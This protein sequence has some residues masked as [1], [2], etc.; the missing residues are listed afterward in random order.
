[1]RTRRLMRVARAIL[2][3]AVVLPS[4]ALVGGGPV[5]AANTSSEML[6]DPVDR[7]TVAI[8]GGVRPFAGRDRYETALRLAERYAHERGGLG[9]ISTVILASGE[10]LVD[11]AVTAGLAGREKAPVL[12][13]PPNGLRG[14]V[15]AFLDRHRISTVIVVGGSSSVPRRVLDQIAALDVEPTV[16][17]IAGADRF[18]T[19]AAVAVEIDSDATWCGTDDTVAVLANGSDER[20]A[21]VVAI[22]PLAY[23]RELPVLLTRGSELPDAAASFLR[24]QRID[25][26]VIVGGES[27]VSDAVM[28]PLL[29]AGVDEIE[30][31]AASRTASVETAMAE[32]MT[33]DCL[34]ELE[35]SK[36]FV[37]L[38]GR[39]SVVDAVAAGPTLGAGFDGSGP[40]PLLL[41]SKPLPRAVQSFLSRTPSA[42]DGR[43]NHVQIVAIGGRGAIDEATMTAA[44]GAAA[45]ARALTARITAAAGANTLRVRFS[46]NLEVDVERFKAKL[47]DLLYVNEVPAWITSQDLVSSNPCGRFS[48]LNVTLRD[49]LEIDDE[50]EF[51][52][53]EGWHSTNGDRR[54]IRGVSYTV[55]EP[56]LSRRA[57]SIEVIA[58][59][60]Q[61]KVWIAVRTAELR[62]PASGAAD[63]IVVSSGRIRV[64]TDDGVAVTVGRP[65]QEGVRPFLG[66]ALYS[67]ELNASAGG[68][69]PLEAGDLVLVRNGVAVGA[70]DQRSGSSRA[71]VVEVKTRLG[72]AAVRAGPPN[73]GVDDSAATTRPDEIANVSRR[74][75]TRLG[76]ALRI[77][78]KWTGS[79]AG[80]A[81][82]A[83][84]I[85]SNRA[86]SP[87]PTP[88][89]TT[90]SDDDRPDTQVWIDASRQL[91]SIRHIEALE[92]QKREQTY[93]ELVQALNRNRDFAEHFIAELIDPCDG[94][95][96]VVDLDEDEGLLGTAELE[97]GV[98]SISFLVTYNEYVKGYLGDD[99]T[100]VSAGG[101]AHVGELI[102]DIL[103]ALI[104]DYDETPTA[105]RVEVST[106]LPLKQVFFRF[107]T[108]DPEHTIGQVAAIRS[109]RVDIRE[110]TVGGYRIDDPATDDV[111]ESVNAE[112]A[113]F[114]V[115]SRDSLLLT[116][117]PAPSS[118]S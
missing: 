3:S 42:V 33:K 117:L 80:A 68:N 105:D 30:R 93:G 47:R 66:T 97:G 25:R 32:L 43:K 91:I 54:V 84:T 40:I 87:V 9:S 64:I 100:V 89:T 4:L 52:A 11:G 102:D 19:A 110:G 23:A 10:T 72:V 83:W 69:Y 82:N 14:D 17:R 59:P 104:P 60:G 88:G 108:A 76:D 101:P 77:V 44:V 98:S 5:H 56:R 28:S 103:G 31:V 21:D 51:Q 109:K 118:N 26:V 22:G 63:D 45:S 96:V 53:A 55:P 74:A 81:G 116:D 71:L 18:A 79:A 61:T 106:L 115:S 20:L 58:I 8:D 92:G 15:A 107:T 48:S 35:P 46:E 50:I 12:L 65:V 13:T 41:V 39:G 70:N 90:A 78:G 57:P 99:Q 36:N 6:V 27:A 24:S 75:Q 113:L 94:D 112:R 7:I 38:V 62:D 1:M 16:R 37:A 85:N 34:H 86:D 111:D 95:E 49:D 29:A 114:V 2:V 67:F 73:P